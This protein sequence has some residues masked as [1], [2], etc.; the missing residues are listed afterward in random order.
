MSKIATISGREF[1]VFNFKEEDVEAADILI[2]LNNI[3]RYGGRCLRFYS[4]AQHA[5]HLTQYFINKGDTELARIAILHDACEAYIGDIIWPIKKEIP[6]FEELETTI[7]NV[8]FNKY[9]IDTSRFEEFDW[10]DKNIVVNEMKALE[11]YNTNAHLLEESNLIGIENYSIDYI[12]N[13][14]LI[15]SALSLAWIDLLNE[16][17]NLNIKNR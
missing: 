2:S 1:D 12:A 15:I 5:L 4:V 9:K 11:L 17:P 16:V 6:V 3:C 8:I 13:T 10:Y 14:Q 7:S